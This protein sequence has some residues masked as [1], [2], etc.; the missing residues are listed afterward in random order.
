LS[1]GQDGGVENAL[2]RRVAAKLLL[3]LARAPAKHHDLRMSPA[4]YRPAPVLSQSAI[5]LRA[6]RALWVS[7]IGTLFCV[8]GL[9]S[10][11]GKPAT[12]A[13]CEQI[14]TR[15]T[16]LELKE[17][18]VADPVQVRAQVEAAKRSFRDRALKECVGKRISKAELDC[19]AQATNAKQIVEECF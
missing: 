19:V 4:P 17:A 2:K 16:E 11:C 6:G 13:D 5:K 18:Q 3:P 1:F 9:L 12:E 10:G 15:V 14:V 8:A 7:R